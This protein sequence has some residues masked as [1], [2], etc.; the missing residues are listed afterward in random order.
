MNTV[1]KV[2]MITSIG[3]LPFA[4]M[5]QS[6]EMTKQ[7]VDHYMQ[8][9]DRAFEQNRELMQE[10]IESGILLGE[11]K[12]SESQTCRSLRVK[13]QKQTS[14]LNSQDASYH[15][16]LGALDGKWDGRLE[17]CEEGLDLMA[18][19]IDR[20][21]S[22]LKDQW[23]DGIALGEKIV[24]LELQLFSSSPFDLKEKCLN[25][26]RVQGVTR[27]FLS[28]EVSAQE[29]LSQVQLDCQSQARIVAQ[30][31]IHHKQRL[32]AQAKKLKKGSAQRSAASIRE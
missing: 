16:K 18:Q 12:L 11:I 25:A 31:F 26:R 23:H 17:G 13:K 1:K 9:Y 7:Q 30:R 27:V 24:A 20:Y 22:E 8:A 4:L 6:Q 5:A 3:L 15:Q 2:L 19:R 29:Q 32:M 28:D 21:K 14:R 10:N